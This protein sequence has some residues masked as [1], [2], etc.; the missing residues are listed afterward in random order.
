ML[1]NP[2]IQPDDEKSQDLSNI[3]YV[4]NAEIDFI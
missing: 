4:F 3:H 2:F 1:Y